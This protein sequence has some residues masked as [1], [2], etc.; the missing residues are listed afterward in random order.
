MTRNQITLLPAALAHVVLA[1]PEEI[2]KCRAVADRQKILTRSSPGHAYPAVQPINW[3]LT[4]EAIFE[5]RYRF[6]DALAFESARQLS[7]DTTINVGPSMV[8]ALDLIAYTGAVPEYLE[9]I[10][11][12]EPLPKALTDFWVGVASARHSW[13][14]APRGSFAVSAFGEAEYWSSSRVAGSFGQVTQKIAGWMTRE[15]NRDIDHDADPARIF[16]VNVSAAA[17]RLERRVNET[18]LG[19]ELGI[20]IDGHKFVAA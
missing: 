16:L 5:S 13:G 1:Q 8:S 11:N 17:R 7:D 20:K 10:A 4:N 9:Y 19:K 2:A 14:D 3:P 18:E 6:S 12:V 15:T